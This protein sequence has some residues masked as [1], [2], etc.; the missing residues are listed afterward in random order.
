M[1]GA[2]KLQNILFLYGDKFQNKYTYKKR[3]QWCFKFNP[4]NRQSFYKT[5][6][7][8]GRSPADSYIIYATPI[9]YRDECQEIERLEV[10][11][12]EHCLIGYARFD[13]A[14]S[15]SHA[16]YL[17]KLNPSCLVAVAPHKYSL[18]ERLKFRDLETE[19][20]NR[21]TIIEEVNELYE[22]IHHHL[23]SFNS[24]PCWKTL[25]QYEINHRKKL[26]T[27]YAKCVS[28]FNG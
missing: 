24:L 7:R 6:L 9:K 22:E 20:L 2:V 23:L 5:L 13:K 15:L 21:D 16:A 10:D 8:L 28:D 27:T 11:V 14:V 4:N 12:I 25:A 18:V 26:P 19:E 1:N 3:S 17:L